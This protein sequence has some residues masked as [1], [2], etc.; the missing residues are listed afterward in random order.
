V[1]FEHGFS[2]QTTSKG[3][4]LFWNVTQLKLLSTINGNSLEEQASTVNIVSILHS[5]AHTSTKYV[6]PG[7]NPV[8]NKHDMT[9]NKHDI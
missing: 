3:N 8:W 6:C 1:A 2:E 4:N 9:W 7:D 5:I